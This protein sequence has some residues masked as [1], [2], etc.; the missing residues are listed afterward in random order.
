MWKKL[1]EANFT[2]G[3]LILGGDFNHLEEIHRK[4]IAKERQMH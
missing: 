1:S 3:H 2:S 4:G